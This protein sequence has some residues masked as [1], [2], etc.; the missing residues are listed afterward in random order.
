MAARKAGKR[1]S[2]VERMDVF[3][4]TLLDQA[5][6]TEGDQI[7][8]LAVKMDIFNRVAGWIAVRNKIA[9]D[10]GGRELDGYRSRLGQDHLGAARNPPNGFRD[11]ESSARGGRRAMA[12]RYGTEHV[13]GD[14]SGLADLKARI[15]QS[16]DGDLLGDLDG[17]GGEDAGAAGADRSVHAGNDDSDRAKQ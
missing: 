8:S 5:S 7:P 15:P 4:G 3:A 16:D 10:E 2:L 11:H 1:D 17:A 6:K 9:E 14:G 12:T 13:E